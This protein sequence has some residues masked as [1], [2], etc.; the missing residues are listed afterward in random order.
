MAQTDPGVIPASPYREEPGTLQR[1]WALF[2][3][4]NFLFA[5]GFAIYSGV[6][7]NFL[8]DRY[9]PAPLQ[10]GQLESLREVPGL[11]AALTAG[12]LAALAESRVAALGLL[13][14]GV[15]IALTGDM[16]GYFPLVGITVLWSVGFHL[17]AAVSPAITLALAKGVE[18]GRHLGRMSAVGALATLVALGVSSLT[19]RLAPGLSYRH[20][21]YAGGLCIGLAA[22]LC[23][24]LSHHAA[25]AP[26]ARLI[27]RRD[28]GLYYLLTFLD[29][30]RRQI[31]SIFASFTLIAVYRAPLSAM[32]LLQF[33]SALLAAMT[34]P[35]I[36]RLID[37]VGERRPL[38]FY[39][40][41][42]IAIFA[43]YATMRHREFLYALFV[44]D[45]VLFNF[46]VGYTTY[47]HRIARPNELTPCVSMGVTMNH[48]AAVTVPFLGAYLWQTTA[49]HQLPFWI[50]IL[51]A[52]ISLQAHYRLPP[53]HPAPAV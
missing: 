11:L 8:R 50:G 29:G 32:L 31:F 24:V 3:A 20:Y 51:V 15:G 53:R 12:T 1:D 22:L 19:A 17:W 37:R 26:R 25:G 40:A 5:F 49:N 35:A 13:L 36:G 2:T 47:L 21:F 30:C 4:L 42:L 18:G 52:G 39:S 45:R 41:T 38:I 9:G 10:L 16:P 14:T 43:G 33:F 34:A 6:F 23:M 48:I 28:Y 44:I 46:S 27:F 7:Q